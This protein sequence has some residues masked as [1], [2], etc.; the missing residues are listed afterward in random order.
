MV[1]PTLVGQALEGSP[2][3]VYGNG[4]QSRCFGYV[5]DAVEVILKLMDSDGAVGEVVN[6]G[7]DEEISIEGLA[8]I[9]LERTRSSSRIEYIPYDRAYEPGFEDMARRVP[10]V[11]KLVRITGIRPTTSLNVIIDKVA[12]YLGAKK[13]LAPAGHA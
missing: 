9:I 5:K 8:S 2:L 6:I 11:E 10:S 1:I 3:T 12:A 4:K 7:N 13:Y